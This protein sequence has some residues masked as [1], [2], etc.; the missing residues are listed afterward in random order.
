MEQQHISEKESLAGREARNSLVY[1]QEATQEEAATTS[2]SAAAVASSK[3]ADLRTL[4]QEEAHSR[5]QAEPWTIFSVVGTTF[6]GLLC[7]LSWADSRGE[8]GSSGLISPVAL[9]LLCCFVLLGTVIWGVQFRLAFRARRRKRAFTATLSQMQDRTQLWGLLRAMDLPNIPLQNLAKQ[10]LIELLPTLRISD[11]ALVNREDRSS[12]V[13]LLTLSPKNL[14]RRVLREAFSRP[15]YR[16]EVDLRIAILKA[17]EQI[18]GEQEIAIVERLADPSSRLSGPLIVPQEIREAAQACLPFVRLH[19]SMERA[20]SQLLRASSAPT[21][22]SE[23]L[24]R[25]AG[26]LAEAPPE[27]LL[28]AGEP[29]A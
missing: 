12:L 1:E 2:A 14:R 19:A 5:R 13:R 6:M 3:A 7:W 11:A 10:R 27:Q 8:G 26:S 29:P 23:I 22:P 16:R 9:T 21:S 20:N 15:A 28:R 18:G 24:L 25:P 17:F 4:L